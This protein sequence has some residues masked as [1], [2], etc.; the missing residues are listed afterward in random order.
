MFLLLGLIHINQLDQPVQRIGVET[1]YTCDLPVVLGYLGSAVDP[2]QP[3]F[4][5]DKFAADH[6]GLT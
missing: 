4:R 6:L 2:F 5:W 3:G 1:L